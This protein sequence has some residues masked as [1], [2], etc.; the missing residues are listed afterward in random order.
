MRKYLIGVGLLFAFSQG[1]EVALAA[2]PPH[3]LVQRKAERFA[4]D[5]GVSVATFVQ[6]VDPD[7]A[8]G[9]STDSNG[10]QENDFDFHVLISAGEAKH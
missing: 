9:V 7:S 1:D 2:R 8:A 4:R 5:E 3:E 6:Y 10:G